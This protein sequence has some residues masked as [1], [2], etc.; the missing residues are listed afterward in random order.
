[1]SN[2]RELNDSFGLGGILEFAEGPGG[3]PVA[4]IRNRAAEATVCLHGAHVMHFQ[5]AGCAPVLWMSAAS[6]F[7]PDKPIRGGIPVCWPWF[8]G[9]PTDPDKPSHGLARI[10]RWSV[11]DT[12][13]P[14]AD[15]TRLV[16][17]LTDT[18]ETRK[19]WPHAFEL[20]LT[21]TVGRTLRLDLET[22]NAGSEPVTIT[23][24]LHTYFS[25]SRVTDIA[26]S[27]FDGCPT[28]D[29]VGGAN[30]SGTQR[31]DITVSAETDLVIQNCPGDAAINDPGLRRRITITKSGSNS[32][33]VWNPWIA[34]A[35]RMPDFGDDEY[36]GMVCVE[37]TNARDDRRTIA[38]G[39][40]HCLTAIIAVLEL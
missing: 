22:K 39:G 23:Q 38:S 25:V 11:A 5:P 28:L 40:S 17:R 26:I 12:A 3:L 10:S 21:I 33:V 13:A 8:G 19:L 2:L 36:P 1:M 14:T 7:A 30:A 9:H 27:G 20:T 16:L 35:K 29:T 4:T 37:T 34:K 31:G 15:E 18:Q 24:A 32:A 6:D